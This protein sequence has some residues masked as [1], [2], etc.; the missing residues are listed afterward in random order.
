MAP[1]LLDTIHAATEANNSIAGHFL[2]DNRLEHHA[3]VAGQGESQIRIEVSCLLRRLYT[4]HKQ[5]E[6]VR[7]LQLL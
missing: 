4:C 3:A 2:D 1:R 6:Q 5:E 7:Y